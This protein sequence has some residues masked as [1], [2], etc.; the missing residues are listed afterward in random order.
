MEEFYAANPL[1]PLQQ[2]LIAPDAV[3]VPWQTPPPSFMKINY[4][5]SWSK[6]SLR[7]GLGVVIHRGMCPKVWVSRP[8]SALVH[9]LSIDGL[10]CTHYFLWMLGS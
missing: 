10:S 2:P 4:D 6:D 1:K 8:P 9:I 7:T 5:A 3:Y